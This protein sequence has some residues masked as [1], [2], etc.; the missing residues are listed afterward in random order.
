MLTVTDEVLVQAELRHVFACIWDVTCWPEL[1]THVKRIEMLEEGERHQRFLMTVESNGKDHTVESVRETEPG[2]WIRYRQVRPP[3]FL[4]EHS[5]EWQFVAVGN[6]VRVDLTHRAEIDYERALLELGASSVE[7]VE[8]VVSQALKINGSK[9]LLAVKSF[10]EQQ[11]LES[12]AA[13]REA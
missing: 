9:T 5:G 7:E 13:A 1:T 3:V 2:R 12:S 10:L 4:E 11:L 6:G 8:G